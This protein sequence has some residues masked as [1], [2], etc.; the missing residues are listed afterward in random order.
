[1]HMLFSP[2]FL[3]G[4]L[5]QSNSSGQETPN[6]FISVKHLER[7]IGHISFGTLAHHILI[8]F[9]NKFFPHVLSF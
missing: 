4:N 6:L 1:M 2:S 7:L 3:S 9:K 8:T 5:E